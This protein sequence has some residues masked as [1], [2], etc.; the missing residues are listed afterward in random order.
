M[1]AARV[2]GIPVVFKATEPS[3]FGLYDRPV[4]PVGTNTLG[5]FLGQ[6]HSLRKLFELK[7]SLWFRASAEGTWIWSGM[8]AKFNGDSAEDLG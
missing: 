6:S 5:L 4:R 2:W 8:S 3:S 1:P 7:F